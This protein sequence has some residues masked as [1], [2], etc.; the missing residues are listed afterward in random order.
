M[1]LQLTQIPAIDELKA[2]NTF[3]LSEHTVEPCAMRA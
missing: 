1:M 3:V 2:L